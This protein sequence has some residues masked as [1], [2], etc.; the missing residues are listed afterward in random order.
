MATVFPAEFAALEPFADWAVPTEKARYA[1]RIASTMDELDAFYSAAFPLLASGTDYLQ[2]VT[3]A[4]ISEE[5]KH[6]LW[7]FC[8]LVTV[9]FSV[10]AWRQ[11]KVPDTG[12]ASIDSVVEPAV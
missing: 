12:A 8:A 10:E 2:R 6:L 3:M 5:D 11:P 7:L 9:A 1:K 4:D